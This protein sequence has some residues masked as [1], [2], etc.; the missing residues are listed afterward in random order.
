MM[1]FW[2][3]DT[4]LD[5][6][7]LMRF[8]PQFNPT[9]DSSELESVLSDV[10]ECELAVEMR[11]PVSEVRLGYELSLSRGVEMSL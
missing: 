1:R 10:S 11:L 8:F 7:R 3:S 6:L 5:T 4:L 2:L 9:A